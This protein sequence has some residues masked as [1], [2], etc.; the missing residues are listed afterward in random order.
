MKSIFNANFI[1]ASNADDDTA[2][3]VFKRNLSF[4]KPIQK[5]TLNCT[6]LGVYEAKVNGNRV[7]DF[8][9]APGWTS[10]H[11]RLQVQSYDITSMINLDD[12]EITVTVGNGWS[13][14]RLVGEGKSHFWE[15]R[16]ALL[17]SI[18]ISYADG[19]IDSVVTD[20]L[21]KVGKSGVLFSEIYDG[22]TFDAR[23]ST[24][25]WNDVTI[26]THPKDALIP[27]EGEVIKEIEEINPIKLF[28]APNGE[29]I[30][31]FGQ[32][33]TGYVKFDV[34]GKMGDICE[35]SHAEILDKDGN[36]YTANMR[37]AKNKIIVLCNGEK[38]CYKPHF[39][40]QGFRYIRIDKWAGE[41]DINAFTA[42]VVHSDMQRTGTFECSN[43]LINQLYKNIIWGQKGNF[44]DVPTDCPQRDERLGWMGDAQVFVRTASYNFDVECFFKK[45]MRD[46][47]ADQYANG[48]MPHVIP[49]VLGE[50]GNSA[51]WGDAAVICPWQ[52]YLTYGDSSVLAEQFIT[53]KKWVCYIRDQG[54]NP[55]LWNNG[56]HF[57]DWLGLDAVEGSYTGSTDQHLIATAYYAYST[58]L[59]IKAGQVLGYN[60]DEYQVLRRNIGE[61]FRKEYMSCGK[62]IS[63]TQTAHVLTL[64]FDLCIHKESLVNRLVE[65]I[66]E[67]GTHLTTGFVGTPYLLHVLSENGKVSLAYKLLLREEY[68]SWLYS[69]N[70]GATTIWEHWDGV[71]PDGSMWSADMNSFNHYAFGAVADFMY[72]VICGI[73]TDEQKPA[74][75][76]ILFKPQIDESM[77]YAKASIQTRQ[78]LVS[79]EWVREGDIV[80]YTFHIP[81]GS[82]AKI[83]LGNN[84]YEVT[85][86][87]HNYKVTALKEP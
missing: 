26:I 44:L 3:P 33:I 58:S 83:V 15:E 70:K 57:G 60:M 18:D 69:V 24:S 63:D 25:V 64:Y 71:K 78:G 41:I 45:W 46:I 14:G 4:S 11:K 22:E 8:F 42:V 6:A 84:L 67:V 50:G 31:D 40:F 55:Y 12:T 37:G 29:H 13:I 21:W 5:V 49:N 87:T 52:I 23:I 16:V 48:G 54:D 1:G 59:L 66:E 38:F 79:S 10:Y 39:T 36:F 35:L 53:M 17:A 82:T 62:L 68:P 51:A 20:S 2:C 76:K 32:N 73:N 85:E 61:A 74:F 47:S 72:G 27:Q 65:L 75:K 81:K 56:E 77:T 43:P 30:I 34:C 9:M 86:G 80:S 7:G 28:T 19:S